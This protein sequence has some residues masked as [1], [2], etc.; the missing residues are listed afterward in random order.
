M[1]YDYNTRRSKL[2]LP[3]YGRNI[4]KMVDYIK[5]QDDREERNRLARALISIMGNMNPHLRD[6]VDFKHKLWDHLAIMANFDLDIDYL[7]EV[8]EPSILTEKP[9]SVA[10]GTHTIR[11][12]HYGKIIE[13]LIDEAVKFP[14][15][16]EKEQL[17]KTIANHMKKSYLTWNRE[18]VS[19]EIILQDLKELSKGKLS[20][21]EDLKLNEIRELLSK[22]KKKRTQPRKK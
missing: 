6:V 1:N 22:N 9:K 11:Y 13:Y 20:V 17:I 12:K 19:D 18:I 10:Y 2:V 5:E 8:P 14:E 4:Q 3:E 7:Y 16:P 15:G 21:N